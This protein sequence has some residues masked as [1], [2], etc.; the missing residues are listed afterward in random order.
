MHPFLIF[1][2]K[3]K[4]FQNFSI[5]V[6]NNSASKN[7]QINPKKVFFGGKDTFNLSPSLSQKMLIFPIKLS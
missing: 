5:P 1:T 7:Y 4:N 6:P 3:K 2:F